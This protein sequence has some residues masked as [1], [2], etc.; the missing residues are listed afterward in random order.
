ML[1]ERVGDDF[2]HID[3]EDGAHEAD[4]RQ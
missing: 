4:S 1:A 2:V 3:A